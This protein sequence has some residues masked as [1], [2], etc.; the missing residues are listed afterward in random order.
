LPRELD[1][2]VHRIG[3][4]ARSGKTGIAMN[5]VTP[6]H[7]RLIFQIEQMTKTRMLEG[8]VP[9]RREIGT[10]K[11]GKLLP[12]FSA[13]AFHERAVEVMNEEWK[14]ALSGMTAEEVAGRFLG[15]MMPEIFVDR[16]TPKRANSEYTGS[17]PN[18]NGGG[19]RDYAPRGGGNGGGPRGHQGPREFSNGGSRGGG[20]RRPSPRDEHSRGEFQGRS[21]DRADFRGAKHH[22]PQTSPFNRQARRSDKFSRLTG[23]GGPGAAGSAGSGPIGEGHGGGRPPVSHHAPT[24]NKVYATR[25]DGAKGKAGRSDRGGVKT[26]PFA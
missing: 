4:T 11:V 9:S 19:R 21:D 5:L 25:G 26:R 13:Q 12:Q 15:M 17:A 18:N 20:D 24:G 6:S 7:R 10:K 23:A 22:P 8:Q 2:Y 14:T 1:S 16:A 3:R